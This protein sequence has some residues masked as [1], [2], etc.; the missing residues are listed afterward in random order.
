ME[1][2]EQVRK[3]KNKQRQRT[4]NC[5]E[6]RKNTEKKSRRTGI[7]VHLIAS[8]QGFELFSCFVIWFDIKF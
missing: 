3:E 5:K 6:S 1:T 7:K 4:S 8:Y 2:E